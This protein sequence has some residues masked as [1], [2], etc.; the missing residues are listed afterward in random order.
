[1]V[2]APDNSGDSI[3]DDELEA[4]IGMS[5]AKT[6]SEGDSDTNLKDRLAEA[7]LHG[8][9]K[10]SS[11]RNARGEIVS[12]DDPHVAV[13]LYE[14]H[15]VLNR[16]AETASAIYAAFK[17][18][19]TD[20]KKLRRLLPMEGGFFEDDSL[21][22]YRKIV[23]DTVQWVIARA[24][25]EIQDPKTVQW[26]DFRFVSDMQVQLPNDSYPELVTKVPHPDDCNAYFPDHQ[27]RD[28]AKK[29]AKDI[30]NNPAIAACI[31]NVGVY[32]LKYRDNR[33]GSLARKT[34]VQHIQTEVNPQREHKIRYLIA[35]M[36][37]IKGLKVPSLGKKSILSVERPVCN[38]TSIEMH[39]YSKT[40][41]AIYAWR[42]ASEDGRGVDEIP[43][44]FSHEQDGDL[45]GKLLLDWETVVLDMEKRRDR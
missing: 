13:D 8:N 27:R 25:G 29:I 12:G 38:D 9:V 14:R 4:I 41:D 5:I 26:L 16:A 42:L 22:H 11:V 3:N 15:A 21:D 36:F 39:W 43:V 10:L 23:S 40:F 31:T 33:F 19:R 35:N 6:L 2:H 28:D 1:V 7:H 17:G 44:K 18:D 30:H 34:A 45:E 20:W 37:R 32:P 24:G